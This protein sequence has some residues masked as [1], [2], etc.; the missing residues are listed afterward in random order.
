MGEG[1]RDWEGNEDGMGVNGGGM[2]RQGDNVKRER[3]GVEGGKGGEWIDKQNER[4]LGEKNPYTFP[5][6]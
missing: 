5:S 2:K 4:R 6:P 3:D 1:W